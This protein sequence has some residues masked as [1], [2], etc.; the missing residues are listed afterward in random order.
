VTLKFLDAMDAESLAP[1]A[2]SSTKISEFN[3]APSNF[4]DGG[5][6]HAVRW[7]QAPP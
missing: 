7:P 5:D 2:Q 3:G 1:P 4:D 6:R